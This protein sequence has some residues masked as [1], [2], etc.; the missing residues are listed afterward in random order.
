MDQAVWVTILIREPN[1][2]SCCSNWLRH[3]ICLIRET[4]K[5]AERSISAYG[6][7]EPKFLI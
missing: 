1:L 2:S 6:G 4:L 3:P 5:N 7:Y